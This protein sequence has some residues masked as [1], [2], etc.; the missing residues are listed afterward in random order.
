[1]NR[2]RRIIPASAAALV[3]ALAGQA[4]AQSSD[5]ARIQELERKLERSLE[6][7]N[8][9]SSKINQIEQANASA[10]DVQ[11]K[12]AQQAEK[13]EAIEKHV[14]EIG[15]S[16]SRRSADSGLPVHGFADVGL[17]KSGENNPTFRGRKGA[18]LGTFDLYLTPQFGDRV[19]GLVELAF[20]ADR[21][22]GI[23]T[24]LERLQIG[25]LFS[26]AATGWLGRFHTPYGYWN[27]AF[28]HGAQIQTSSLRPRFLDFEDK[29]GIL[30]AH[31]TGA[32]LTGALGMSGGKFGYDLFVGNAPQINGNTTGTT[33][34]TSNP[35]GFSAAVNAGTYAGTGT[36]NMRQSGSTTGRTST[37]F[38]AWY[39]PGAVDGL[40]LGLHGMRA[41]VADDFANT[42]LLNMSGGYFAFTRDP[43]EVLGEYYRFRNNDR[44]GGTGTH[45]SWA[46]YTQIGY[47]IAKWTPF[48]RIERAKLDQTDNYFGVQESG[49]SYKR[50]AVGLRYDV[51]PKA[52]LKVEFAST[53]K[54]NLGPGLDDK[55]PELRVQYAVSF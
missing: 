46:G 53:R 30:P 12:T 54:E 10:R 44:S 1:M 5:A 28:H 55:Y 43:W 20:E 6:L 16:L 4:Q 42:T 32:W 48:A 3:L 23:A 52:A 22:G 29:G 17:L 14:S 11:A 24:D 49:R 37:G 31:T 41:E 47:N 2:S 33:L 50:W 21:D 36:M 9:L 19:K 18:A 34:A 38:N 39:E 25:Y 35:T 26:D 15:G 27:T 40:R 45:A 8:Q 51:D 13:L 7:I